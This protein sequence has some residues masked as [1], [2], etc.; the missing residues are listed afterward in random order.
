M[1][2]PSSSPSCNGSAGVHSSPTVSKAL[3]SVI[4]GASVQSLNNRSAGHHVQW[5]D[6]L[7]YTR[8]IPAREP[9]EANPVIA[10]VTPSVASDYSFQHDTGAIVGPMGGLNLDAAASSAS[11]APS[12]YKLPP[13]TFLS[14]RP[15]LTSTSKVAHQGSPSLS[16]VPRNPNLRFIFL[17]RL[18]AAQVRGPLNPIDSSIVN[19][20]LAT[21]GNMGMPSVISGSNFHMTELQ[22]L[23]P[24]VSEAVL[25]QP[26]GTPPRTSIGSD[27]EN[28]LLQKQPKNQKGTTG[29]Q[30]QKNILS[31][32]IKV[33]TAKRR[34]D[35]ESS[36]TSEGGDRKRLKQKGVLR[37]RLDSDSATSDIDHVTSPGPRSSTEPTSTS[38]RFSSSSVEV[39]DDIVPDGPRSIA[40][41]YNNRAKSS[42]SLD[43]AQAPRQSARGSGVSVVE[44]THRK[45]APGGSAV[46]S[47]SRV[48]VEDMEVSDPDTASEVE[49][50]DPQRARFYASAISRKVHMWAGKLKGIPR[51][52]LDSLFDDN[53]EIMSKG[54]ILKLLRDIDEDKNW[55]T[56]AEVEDTRLERFLIAVVTEHLVNGTE[57]YKLAMRILD[58]FAQRFRGERYPQTRR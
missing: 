51:A 38:G 25:N 39:T 50:S 9:Q 52:H 48:R 36:D 14:L 23:M 19:E 17:R 32:S 35:S 12:G 7:V 5:S 26:N 13:S 18:Q 54:E 29:T 33:N 53:V 44:R 4:S 24:V 22:S 47:S 10:T 40:D 58:N 57:A 20:S 2:H 34:L 30:K 1:A 15:Q 37:P 16:A 45:P 31:T 46:A 27:E 11:T 8:G 56:R 3:P 55:A 43:N 6:P 42:V 28:S 41:A 49:T 21:T